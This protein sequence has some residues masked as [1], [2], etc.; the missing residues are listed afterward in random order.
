[1]HLGVQHYKVEQL[2]NHVTT[3]TLNTEK[4]H[5]ASHTPCVLSATLLHKC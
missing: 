5:C 2:Y 1:M 3:I 4:L